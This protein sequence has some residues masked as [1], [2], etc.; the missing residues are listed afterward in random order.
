ML[1]GSAAVAAWT[2]EAD[3][4]YA[5]RH[6]QLAKSGKLVAGE[7][8][9]LR[10]AEDVVFRSPSAASAVILGRPDNGRT[11]W[12]IAGGN[13]SYGDWQSEQVAKAA[14]DYGSEAM[15]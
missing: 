9:L 1:K 10:F 14:S 13:I 7:G 3:H 8:K 11:S 2:S 4:S 5:K 15:E 6:T 12:K